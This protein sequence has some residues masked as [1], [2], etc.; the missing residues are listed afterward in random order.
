MSTAE[1]MTSIP[2]MWCKRFLGG[3]DDIM[4]VKHQADAVININK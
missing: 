1:N 3:L 4:Y 2:V